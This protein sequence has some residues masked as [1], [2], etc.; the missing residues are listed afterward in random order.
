MRSTRCGATRAD[1][2]ASAAGQA[3]KV[4]FNDLIVKACAIALPVPECNAQFTPEGDLLVHPEVDI[5]V[6]VAVAGGS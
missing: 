5:S 3:A 1:L 2:A 4:S 6:A